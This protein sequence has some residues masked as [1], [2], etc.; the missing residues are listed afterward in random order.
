VRVAAGR[1]VTLRL[2]RPAR[3]VRVLRR[4]LAAAGPRT[5]RIAIRLSDSA[6]NVRVVRRQVRVRP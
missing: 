6:G 4:A 3:R 2:R 1:T 5:A